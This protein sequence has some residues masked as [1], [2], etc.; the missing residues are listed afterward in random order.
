ML[1]RYINPLESPLYR[2][3]CDVFPEIA[4]HLSRESDL[5][6]ATHVSYHLRNA[7]FSHP[8]LWSHLDFR[9]ATRA[10]AFLE[11]S[12]QVPLHIS[13][14]VDRKRTVVASLELR[15]RSKRIATLDLPDWSVQKAFLS[16]PL[17]SLRS[18]TVFVDLTGMRDAGESEDISL[19][20][21]WGPK[22]KTTSWSFP[23]LT[24]LIV[25]NINPVRF[26]TPHLTRFQ[27]WEWMGSTPGNHLLGFLDNC[28]LLEH[29]DIFFPNSGGRGKHDLV[30]SLP[31]LRTFTQ[32]TFDQVFP[33]T[34]FN[35]LSLPAFCSVTLRFRDR[36][37][38]TPETDDVLPPFKNTDYLTEIKRV[39]LRTIC[40]ADG[41]EVAGML[42][43]VN[44]QGTRVSSERMDNEQLVHPLLREAKE[45][46]HNAAHLNFLRSLDGRSVEI[47]CID[48]CAVQDVAVEFLKEA[49]GLG[50]VRTLILSRSAVWPCLSAL[51]ED[52][53]TAGQSRWFLPLHTLIVGPDPDIPH[54]CH[55]HLES[56]LSVAQK[57]KVAG[58]P[59]RSVSL[60]LGAP[61][62]MRDQ[63]VDGLRSCVGELEVV[64]GDGVLDWDVDKYFRDG[65]GH[66]QMNRDVEWDYSRWT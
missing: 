54:P 12:G 31:R 4:S 25:E 18:L 11:R 34:V 7:L 60:F 63:I 48:G 10:R 35:M 15:R 62:Q 26:H 53:G 37:E 59:F 33:L 28:P 32:T 23:S 1:R 19:G 38:T 55:Q 20:Q 40:D 6:N 17:P 27:I 14:T 50:N 56:L 58:F 21:M 29:I 44:A 52:L 2:L 39:K 61:E 46:P 51:G 13:M 49:L 24:S 5:V 8:S 64:V 36:G 65:L 42:E 57:K 47:L 41:Y 43:L 66:L 30:V 45:Y 16:E 9:F 22:K 3:P